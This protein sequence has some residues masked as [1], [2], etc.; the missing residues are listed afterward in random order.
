MT[1]NFTKKVVIVTGGAS[2]IGFMVAKSFSKAGAVVVIL[3]RQINKLKEAQKEIQKLGYCEIY[4]ADVSKFN[5]L[6]K[7]YSEIY[8]KYKRIDV[9]VNC[10]GVYG[11]IGRFETNDMVLWAEAMNINLLGTAY[12]C[13]AVL[14]LMLKKKSGKIINLS[15]GGAVQP[16]PNFSCYATSKAAVVRFTEN[17][18]K[19]F[20][21]QNIQVNAIAPGAINTLFL[22]K[23]LKAG[24]KK[25]GKEFYEKSLQQKKSG[26]DSAELAAELVLSLC[27]GKLTGKVIS[28]KWDNWQEWNEE[29]VENLNKN[30]E[31]TLRRIDNKYFHSK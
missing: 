7:I 18:A 28:A 17:L 11:P 25:V 29:R 5:T 23:V 21:D 8:K 12:S 10:A 14:P 31:F 20:E 19:E 3:G 22:D 13:N 6:K 2:G 27:S 26:G 15:G 9:L 4:K 16:F 1:Y 24:V 30:S